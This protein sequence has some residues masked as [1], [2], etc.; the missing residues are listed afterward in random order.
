MRD[1]KLKK[2]YQ[3]VY[4]KALDKSKDISS[5]KLEVVDKEN[6]TIGESYI[7]ENGSTV[8]YIGDGAYEI[9]DRTPLRTGFYVKDLNEKCLNLFWTL[10]K[11]C[12]NGTCFG[13]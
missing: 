8:S 13:V 10:V 6:L 1:I 5:A 4:Y 2:Y 3:G 9:I 12:K 7:I 11:N